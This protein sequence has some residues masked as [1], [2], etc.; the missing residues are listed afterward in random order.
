MK[1]T[2]AL[3]LTVCII[4]IS[5]TAASGF[6]QVL[7]NEYY[8]E[9]SKPDKPGAVS[10]SGKGGT[11][12]IQ[13]NEQRKNVKIEVGTPKILIA[14]PVSNLLYSREQELFTIFKSS[15]Y[16]IIK[17]TGESL[18][19][20]SSLV[21]VTI[22]ELNNTLSID[23][24]ETESFDVYVELPPNISLDIT[25]MNG[26]I[27]LSDYKGLLK[28]IHIQNNLNIL[29][30]GIQSPVTANTTNGS[31]TVDFLSTSFEKPM[32]FV[33]MLKD[34]T[35]I[36]PQETKETLVINAGNAIAVNKSLQLSSVLT[37]IKKVPLPIQKQMIKVNLTVKVDELVR[38]LLTYEKKYKLGEISIEELTK[39]KN[40]YNHAL[41]QLEEAIRISNEGVVAN[42]SLLPFLGVTYTFNIN[43]GGATIKANAQMGNVII[44]NK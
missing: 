3:S 15:E 11:M 19:I 27:E 35:L 17:N 7:K 18:T 26:D 1:R 4:L 12:Y 5:L 14:L 2:T 21:K 31:I 22:K 39:A 37:T 16:E 20:D 38:M 34:I 40:N 28:E 13:A 24:Q 10:I 30:N 33:S 42:I 32:S 43:G 9:F 8:A 23:V 6:G 41:K 36:F 25:Y 44:K 29:L